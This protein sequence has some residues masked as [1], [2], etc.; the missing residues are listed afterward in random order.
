[1]IPW[2]EKFEFELVNESDI[3][4]FSRLNMEHNSVIDLAFASRELSQKSIKWE[5]NKNWTTGSDHEIVHIEIY[6]NGRNLVENPMLAVSFNLEKVDWGKFR[7]NLLSLEKEY[8]WDQLSE[9][10]ENLE[11]G[12]ELLEIIIKLAAEESI[13]KRKNSLFSKP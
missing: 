8:E 10:E 12:V 11:K 13:P 7:E 3:S 4:I 6:L 9:M 2:L 1:L 5:I